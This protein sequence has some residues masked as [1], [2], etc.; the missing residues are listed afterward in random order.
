MQ[1]ECLQTSDLNSQ[2]QGL[3]SFPESL[4]QHVIYRKIYPMAIHHF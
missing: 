3:Q 1:N 4:D 2:A